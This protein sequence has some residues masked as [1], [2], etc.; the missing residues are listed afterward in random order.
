MS[1]QSVLLRGALVAPAAPQ[2]MAQRIQAYTI[3]QHGSPYGCVSNNMCLPWQ[4][5]KAVG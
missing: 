1:S 2:P 4:G 3:T 5:S